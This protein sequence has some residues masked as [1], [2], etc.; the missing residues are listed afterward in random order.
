MQAK[1]LSNKDFCGDL[2]VA[3]DVGHSSIGWAVLQT[4]KIGKRENVS[5]FFYPEIAGCGVVI[6]E[7]DTCLAKKRREYR[8]QRRHIRSTRQR[9]KR[10]KTLLEYLRVLKASELDKPGIQCPWKLAAEVLK[11]GRLLTWQE[12]WD[13]LRWYAHNR[14]YDENKLW[15]EHSKDDEEDSGRVKKA[16]ELMKKYHCSSMAETVCKVAG[17]CP[18]GSDKYNSE[19]KERFKGLGLAFPRDIV[20]NEVREIL[21]K[22]VGKLI[23]VN[24]DLIETLIGDS[25]D[26]WKT[27]PCPSIKLP[28]RYHGGLLFGQLR[29]RFNNRNITE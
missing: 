8:R 19:N 15:S 5:D 14:G 29:P 24:N 26:A 12:L 6:F 10:I 25:K 9:I 23:G 4:G 7:P 3:F 11:N 28:S 1:I 17:I 2:E 16:E 22:H 20:V 18:N 13:V 21:Q 27:I